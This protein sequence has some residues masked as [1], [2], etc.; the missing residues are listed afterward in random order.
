MRSNEKSYTANGSCSKFHNSVV[1]FCATS[2]FAQDRPHKHAIYLRQQAQENL[3][4]HVQ[5]KTARVCDNT[6]R[7]ESSVN[8][9]GRL[10]IT[11]N[12]MAKIMNDNNNNN[13]LTTGDDR[14]RLQALSLINDCNKYKWI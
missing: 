6:N 9:L 1:I 12:R 2:A 11:I 13:T 3:K 4:I 5:K 7:N 8:S 14:T 10:L